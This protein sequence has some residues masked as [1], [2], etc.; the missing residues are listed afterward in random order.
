MASRG[1]EE[2]GVRIAGHLR[3]KGIPYDKQLRR[4]PWQDP[5][6]DALATARRALR[7]EVDSSLDCIP[8]QQSADLTAAQLLSSEWQ[9][10]FQQRCIDAAMQ[11]SG[12]ANLREPEAI[13]QEL[14]HGSTRALAAITAAAGCDVLLLSD[15]SKGIARFV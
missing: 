1:A 9:S 15:E 14:S 2:V 8:L 10:G 11:Q 4:L 6:E 13:Q 12:P 5:G 3:G 7:D